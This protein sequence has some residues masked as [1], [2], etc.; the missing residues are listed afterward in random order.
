MAGTVCILYHGRKTSCGLHEIRGVKTGS[1]RAGKVSSR[2]AM[3]HS[4]GLHIKGEG[5]AL[6][7]IQP[8]PDMIQ[9]P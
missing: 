3:E 8:L 4:A 5:D 7:E 2:L 9:N 6:V 1:R